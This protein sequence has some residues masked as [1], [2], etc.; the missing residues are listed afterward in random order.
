L[1]NEASFAGAVVDVAEAFSRLDLGVHRTT[2][3]H[4][5]T[6]KEVV[7]NGLANEALTAR[8]EFS[9]D[10]YDVV[11]EYPIKVRKRSFVAIDV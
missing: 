5:A 1:R 10:R 2:G 7:A 3:K 8:T 4:L 6:T 9:N 11:M